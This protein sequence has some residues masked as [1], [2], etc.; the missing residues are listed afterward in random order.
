MGSK[1]DMHQREDVRNQ[2]V[3]STWLR[4]KI[5]TVRT[6]IFDTGLLVTG[7]AVERIMKPTSLVPTR[8]RLY[9]LSHN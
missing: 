3:D 1:R 2:R 6:W 7:A 8:V 4:T 5:E 9:A